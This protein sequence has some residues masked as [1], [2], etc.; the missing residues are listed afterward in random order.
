MNVFQKG[1]MSLFPWGYL[2]WLLCVAGAT[3]A[4]MPQWFI[5][6]AHQPAVNAEAWGIPL[7]IIGSILLIYGWLPERK[8]KYPEIL[9]N[10]MTPIPDYY[11]KQ[12]G[13]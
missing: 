10:T 8:R 2:G 4:S 1:E 9:E 7:L 5:V 6:Y 3:I 13:S 11:L 12:E